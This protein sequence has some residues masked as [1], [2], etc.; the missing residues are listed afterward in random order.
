MVHRIF[1]NLL[2]MLK[3]A[4]KSFRK[5]LKQLKRLVILFRKNFSV[6]KETYSVPQFYPLKISKV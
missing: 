1:M 5:R 4:G 6:V 3:R 2:A